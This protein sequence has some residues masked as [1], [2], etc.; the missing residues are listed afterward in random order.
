MKRTTEGAVDVLCWDC[1]FQIDPLTNWNA[2]A[3]EGRPSDNTPIDDCTV[4]TNT[5]TGHSMG[6]VTR[7]Q[8]F[9]AAS[10][11]FKT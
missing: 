6:Q 3:G 10:D 8:Q 1:W 2:D 5:E 4:G 7:V 9:Q 11:H